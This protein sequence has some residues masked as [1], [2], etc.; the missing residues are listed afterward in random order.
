MNH[1]YHLISVAIVLVFAH[2]S[3]A[4]EADILKVETRYNGNNN[5]QVIVTVQ[6]KDTGWDHYAKGWEILDE[7]GRL[8]G[9]RVLHH[10]HVK[11]QPFTRSYTLDIPPS[12][13]AITVR[14]VDSVHGRGGK[15]ILIPLKRH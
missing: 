12:M 9:T 15:T 6:H 13:N 3:G 11:E 8:L 14:G 4:G 5:F 7:Q 2:S 1:L 10:P